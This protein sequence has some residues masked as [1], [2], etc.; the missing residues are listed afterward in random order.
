MAQAEALVGALKD[1]LKARGMTYAHLSKGLGLSEASVKRVFAEQSFTLERLDQI[2]SLLGM[3]ISD[4]A[5]MVAHQAA[6]PVQLS[7]QQESQLVADPRLL[8]IAVHA[9][10][11][12][13]LDEILEAF[14][15]TKAECIR[16]LARLDKLG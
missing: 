3:Q 4:L 16:L 7:Q 1:V 10:N 9:V 12:W 14:A 8:L 11:H 6:T 5:R 13:T 15:F 2:C